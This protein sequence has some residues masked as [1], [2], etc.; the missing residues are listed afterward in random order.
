MAAVYPKEIIKLAESQLISGS[1]SMQKLVKKAI[2]E[3]LLNA[4]KI[5]AQ[6]IEFFANMNY[7]PEI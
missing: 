4:R 6:E 1:L 7:P 3:G 2:T 5:T